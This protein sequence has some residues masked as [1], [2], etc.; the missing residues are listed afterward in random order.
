M[1]DLTKPNGLA[2]DLGAI[3]G[4]EATSRLL[5]VYGGGTLYIPNEASEKHPIAAVIGLPAMRHLCE[6]FG[7]QILRVPEHDEFRRLRLVR[8]VARLLSLGLS[9]SAV[10][11]SLGVAPRQVQRYRQ[12]AEEIGLLPYVM[13][14]RAGAGG[15]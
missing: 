7:G 4:F 11:D 9:Y 10:A 5:A 8:S 14:G 15:G 13:Q 6:E 12:Q 3:L 2:E 1:A